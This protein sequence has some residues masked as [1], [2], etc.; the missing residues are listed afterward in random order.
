MLFQ[1]N[2]IQSGDKSVNQDS[3][4]MARA[5]EL[6]TK[7]LG[8][9]SPNPLVGCVIV[10]DGRIVGEGYH[11]KAGTPHAE[12]H[13]L[14][15]AQTMAQ[16]ATA[17]VTLEP[18]SHF[19][20][21]PPCAN[22]LIEAGIK[23]VVVAMVDPNPLVSGKGIQRLQEAG[24]EVEVGLMEEEARKINKGFL[25]AITTGL[26]YVLYKSALTLDGKIATETGDSK[27][28]TN[29]ASRAYA[30]RLRDQFDVIMVG[31]ETVLQDNPA[32]NCRI[33]NG[34]DP[35]RLIVD[36]ELKLPLEASI[37][38][39]SC[40]SPCII[41]TTTSASPTKIQALESMPNVEVWKYD[42]QRYV[43]LEK[44]LRDIVKRGWNSVLLE[45]GG[46]LAGS[47]LQAQ[48]IDELDFI[49]APKLIGGNGPSPLA[50]MKIP[51][52]AQ[53]IPLEILETDLTTGDLRVRA[54][55]LSSQAEK[56]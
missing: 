35:V 37:L 51:L 39:S 29:E 41:A 45:G 32:L 47:L 24:I 7:A 20:K 16:G 50:G 15:A 18:C 44:M 6:A 49:F 28:I 34:R 1:R 21:T 53:A 27:W 46:R 52:M 3:F 19:G 13:A 36:G 14:N 48:L 11:Q 30:H 12:V 54:K 55:V 31:S 22:A 38:N 42:T 56:R 8:R 10:K 43:P 33:E 17:Y 40:T 4:Y 2:Q 25:K 9:T 26:P 5:I 23:R